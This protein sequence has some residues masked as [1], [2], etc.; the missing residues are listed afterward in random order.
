[1]EPT[2]NDTFLGAFHVQGFGVGEKMTISKSH[3][4]TDILIQMAPLDKVYQREPTSEFLEGT[5]IYSGHN[6]I[7]MSGV[8]L[9]LNFIHLG[10]CFGVIFSLVAETS[11][12]STRAAPYYPVSCKFVNKKA[13]VHRVVI[14]IV[15]V[16]HV[17][18]HGKPKTSQFIANYR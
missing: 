12:L 16:R 17:I 14:F 6:K 2:K 7:M 4:S 3:F 1:M 11:A 18:L 9:F 5:V 15:P 13:I 8:F 10:F